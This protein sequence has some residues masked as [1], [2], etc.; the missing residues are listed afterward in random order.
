M[1]V[2]ERAFGR[3]CRNIQT[4]R[5]SSATSSSAEVL[6]NSQPA[7]AAGGRNKSVA[8]ADQAHQTSQVLRT[9][10]WEANSELTALA[11]LLLCCLGRP[12]HGQLL[13]LR[14][15][16]AAYARHRARRRRRH[17]QPSLRRTRR[18]LLLAMHQR[19]GMRRLCNIRC[20]VLSQ[21]GRALQRDALRSHRL[22]SRR[23]AAAIAAAAITTRS[24][25]ATTVAATAVAATL[26][27]AAF[28]T[29]LAAAFTAAV[30]TAALAAAAESAAA[31]AANAAARRRRGRA[32]GPLVR[33]DDLCGRRLFIPR[34]LQRRRVLHASAAMAK[35]RRS[36]LLCARGDPRRRP[37]RR[38]A[39]LDARAHTHAHARPIA[40]AVAKLSVAR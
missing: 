2:N 1:V 38:A 37:R 18:K 33:D 21:I 35:G 9:A 30:T 22:H 25:T 16:S 6:S 7:A 28:T 8:S 31:A 14:S 34:L 32:R 27:A 5:S 11:V 12:R 17:P 24:I 19:P 15:L 29:T 36:R 26:T 20:G 4:Q 40:N 23:R 3:G 13:E 39:G 10:A